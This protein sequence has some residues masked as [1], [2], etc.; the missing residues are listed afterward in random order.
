[1]LAAFC[2]V[3]APAWA[4]P[5]AVQLGDARV[6]LDVP[7][8]FADTIFT[9]SPRLQELAESLTSPSNRILVFAISDGDL[10]RF[11][12]GDTPDFRRHLMVVIPK[13]AERERVTPESFKRFASDAL[14]D[15]GK[16]PTETDYPN[17]LE[18]QPAE[19]LSL[20]AELRRDATAISVLQGL[21]LPP[22][23][24][25]GMFSRPEPSRF[26]LSSTSL[27]L[28]RG[29]GLNLSVFTMYESP[30]DLDWIRATTLRW[31]EDLQR[32]NSR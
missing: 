14:R 7:V 11:T 15:M 28:L 18:Q 6:A 24:K 27:V 21:R 20:L 30:G 3:A 19:Q 1:L 31:I 26:V 5:F 25:P 9:G 10:R 23:K 2:L 12:V 13:G 8:G 16:A 32:L 29:R 22:T 4:A 17:Y